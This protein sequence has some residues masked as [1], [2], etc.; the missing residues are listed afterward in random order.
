MKPPFD[1]NHVFISILS[2]HFLLS[3]SCAIFSQTDFD[4]IPEPGASLDDSLTLRFLTL[5]TWFPPVWIPSNHRTERLRM[6]TDSLK[7]GDYDVICLQEVFRPSTR[8]AVSDALPDYYHFSSDECQ[9]RTLCLFR[10]DCYGGLLTLSKYP[11]LSEEFV[12]FPEFKGIKRVEKIAGKGF[13]VTE[14]ETAAGPVRV[15]NTHLHYGRKEAESRIR[16]KQTEF[17]ANWLKSE[18]IDDAGPV[19]LLGDLN[20]THPSLMKG[21]SFPDNRLYSIITDTLGFQEYVQYIGE[22]DLTYDIIMNPYSY[23]WYNRFEGRQKFDYI[24]YR[25][26]QDFQILEY[27]VVYKGR[28]LLSDHFGLMMTFRLKGEGNREGT[29]C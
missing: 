7:T 1:K 9:K 2:L 14:I 27:Q 25:M 21:K 15:V 18:N 11:V 24:F 10:K 26:N 17:L 3:S 28:D 5:N 16:L 6:L 4:D 29:A 8:K 13:L 20:I 22:E 23:L 19:F 12:R